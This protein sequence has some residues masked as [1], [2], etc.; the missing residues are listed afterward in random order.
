MS[1]K[2]IV[3]AVWFALISTHSF[4]FWVWT[5]ET[6]QWINPKYAVKETPQLQLEYALS[7]ADQDD[8][9]AQAEEEMRKLIKH[10]PK[11][12]EAADAQ[13]YIAQ[14]EEQRGDFS[15]A[16]ESYQQVIK[17]YPFTQRVSE[18][19]QRQYEMASRI[20]D[21]GSQDDQGIWK[22]I[23]ASH[24]NLEEIFTQVIKNAPYG[25]YAAPSQY[26]IGLYL[27]EEG[28]MQEARDAFEKT[29]NDYP[30]SEWAKAARYQIAL[31]D[32]TRSAEAGY[33]Q[34]I[35]QSAITEFQ[36]FVREYPDAR[37]SAEARQHIVDLREKEAENS[38][39]IARFYERQKKYKA[40]RVYYLQ[41]ADQYQDTSWAKKAL[42]AIQQLGK[43]E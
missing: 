28:L 36:E 1:K 2:T 33:D 20:L 24:V 5:P 3:L 10:Y 42:E 25:E 11:S 23:I 34:K 29:L 19:V 18:V 6:R 7:L 41:I 22:K 39:L 26:K 38:F 27:K 16:F 32:A 35:T 12:R 8:G 9:A 40:A 13:F 21:G 37:L 31:A 15:R 30:D 43:K 17:K 4:A 14:F